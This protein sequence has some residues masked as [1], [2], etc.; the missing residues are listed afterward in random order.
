MKINLKDQQTYLGT[1]EK[2]SQVYLDP[3]KVIAIRLDMRAGGSFVKGLLKPWDYVFS[4][5]MKAA[6]QALMEQVSGV[7]AVYTG[8]DEITLVLYPKNHAKKY[9]G[10]Q[11]PFFNGRTDK[12]LSLTSS[13]ATN[14][15]N[16]EWYQFIQCTRQIGVKDVEKSNNLTETH[17][18]TKKFMKRIEVLENKLFKAQFDSRVFQ[19]DGEMDKNAIDILFSRM[20]D[21]KKNSIQMLARAHFS[22][23]EL[24][25]KSTTEQKQ[26]LENSNVYWEKEVDTENKYGVLFYKTIVKSEAINKLTGEQVEVNRNKIFMA[27]E[28]ELIEFVESKTYPELYNSILSQKITYIEDVK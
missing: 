11:I 3:N 23:K 18:I 8:S 25:N 2:Y 19:V 4:A 21:V 24:Q 1:F 20:N 27:T 16:K 13:I 26:M 9:N 10:D 15:F 7:V 22:H 5:S 14:A 12:L 28:P 17:E 6:A